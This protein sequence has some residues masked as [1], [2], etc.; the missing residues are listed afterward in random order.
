MGNLTETAE[1]LMG[2]LPWS[3]GY[4]SQLQHIMSTAIHAMNCAFGATRSKEPVSQREYSLPPV[5]SFQRT[6]VEEA[7]DMETS[8]EVFDRPQG[9][10]HSLAY[11]SFFLQA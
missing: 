1:I 9:P 10:W 4:V 5:L 6:S 2:K 8:L 11:S 7:C 3:R